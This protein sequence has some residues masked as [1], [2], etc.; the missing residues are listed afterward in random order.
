MPA[1]GRVLAGQRWCALTTADPVTRWSTALAVVGIAGVAAVVS[2][3]Y[4]SALIRAH[5]K[6]GWTGRL[7]A[8]TV[9]RLIYASSMVILDSA[10]RSVRVSELARW[11]RSRRRWMPCCSSSSGWACRRRMTKLA[12]TSQQTNHLEIAVVTRLCG[13][14]LAN[15]PQQPRDHQ[16]IVTRASGSRPAVLENSSQPNRS[17]NHG[18][19]VETGSTL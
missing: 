15:Q 5:G 3:E 9:D 19:D 11:L 8:L 10:R 2:Y 7:I 6:S 18:R 1:H 14:L 4:A 12:R 13:A 17:R 16:G